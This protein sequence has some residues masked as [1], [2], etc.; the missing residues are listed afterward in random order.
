MGSTSS[1]LAGRCTGGRTSDPPPV[2]CL[3]S[4]SRRAVPRPVV[5]RLAQPSVPRLACAQ[6]SSAARPQQDGRRGLGPHA[7]AAAPQRVPQRPSI[8]L[9][10]R[11]YRGLV[12][13]DFCEHVPKNQQ[14]RYK[15][16]LH[17]AWGGSIV[18]GNAREPPTACS[19]VAERQ[20]AGGNIRD[21]MS[22]P[23][24]KGCSSM[25]L[26]SHCFFTHFPLAVA[27]T[28]RTR[29]RSR[30][31]TPLVCAL[32]ETRYGQGTVSHRQKRHVPPQTP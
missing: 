24:T 7:H 25:L 26:P 14:L 17:S 31:T 22:G 5:P 16:E 4:L 12:L 19:I 20:A 1:G 18:W 6:H 29:A 3:R 28:P 10:G 2:P 15:N 8:G 9:F 13:A 27:G 21:A 11:E 30:R 32:E 23:S